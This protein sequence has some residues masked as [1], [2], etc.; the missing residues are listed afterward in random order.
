MGQGA[1]GVL[2]A[3]G[4]VSAA[5]CFGL[6]LL[7]TLRLMHAPRRSTPAPRML[8]GVALMLGVMAL[9]LALIDRGSAVAPTTSMLRLGASAALLSCTGIALTVMSLG[10]TRRPWRALASASAV[11]AASTPLVPTFGPDGISELGWTTWL[12]AAFTISITTLIGATTHLVTAARAAFGMAR[13]QLLLAAAGIS[14]FTLAFPIGTVAYGVWDVSPSWLTVAFWTLVALASIGLAPP[15][16][17]RLAL[18]RVARGQ[19]LAGHHRL[20]E[21]TTRA[22]A[23]DAIMP[24][25]AAIWGTE[26]LAVLDERNAVQWA[27]GLTDSEVVRLSSGEAPHQALRARAGEPTVLRLRRGTLI[28]IPHPLAAHAGFVE[29]EQLDGVALELDM[30]LLAAER[31]A[32]LA[33]ERE[34]LARLQSEQDLLN[35]DNASLRAYGRAIAHD[36]K[37]PLTVI[38]GAAE[39]VAALEDLSPAGR[40]L[41]DRVLAHSDRVAGMIDDQ[42]AAAAD[43]RQ[44]EEF[45]AVEACEW[46]QA[47]LADELEELHCALRWTSSLPVVRANRGLVQRVLLN[48]ARNALQHA[49]SDGPITIW[50]HGGADQTILV[51]DDGSGMKVDE[52]ARIFDPG[53]RHDSHGGSGLGLSESRAALRRLGGDL[54]LVDTALGTGTTLAIELPTLTTGHTA[55]HLG[56]RKAPDG[57]GSD[58]TAPELAAK[59]AGRA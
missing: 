40:D 17:V 23:L 11:L 9:P 21:A 5:T 52:A 56:E 18:R 3:A 37:T 12:I 43:M 15:A 19:R 29:E 30:A 38:R 53:V 46:L 57:L 10:A 2:S 31:L 36:I 58:E 49:S 48:L 51:T 55:H 59:A 50:V 26:A 22:E 8:A 33:E 39:T 47:T 45:S 32:E 34:A 20:M 28:A 42:L 25:I 7:A 16:P 41:L 14:L 24:G 44:V 54:W 35:A 4:L 6:G 13:A 1:Q 27:E